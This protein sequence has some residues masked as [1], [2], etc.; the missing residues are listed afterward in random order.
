MIALD[1]TTAHEFGNGL[2]VGL[3]AGA[4]IGALLGFG[5]AFVLMAIRELPPDPAPLCPHGIPLHS[6][7]R[8]CDPTVYVGPRDG[9][10]AGAMRNIARRVPP[11]EL[12]S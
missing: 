10:W 11:P 7:C 2:L 1:P 3:S 4:M 5:A 8:Q 9:D 6:I 12:P